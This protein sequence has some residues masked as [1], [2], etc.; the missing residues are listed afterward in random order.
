MLGHPARRLSR[1][2]NLSYMV[3][4]DRLLY[5]MFSNLV[6]VIR[7]IDP[8]RSKGNM[9][10][11]LWSVLQ[12]Q[13]WF[14]SCRARRLISPHQGK[15]LTTS[16]ADPVYFIHFTVWYGYFQPGA[17]LDWS[18]LSRTRSTKRLITTTTNLNMKIPEDRPRFSTGDSITVSTLLNERLGS[19]AIDVSDHCIDQ[20]RQTIQCYGDRTPNHTR[21]FDAIGQAFVVTDTVHTCRNFDALREWTSAK[22]NET[23]PYDPSATGWVCTLHTVIVTKQQSTWNLLRNLS[24]DTT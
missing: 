14:L 19:T 21:W 9:A 10:R 17:G 8:G 22:H 12:R 20:L 7:R 15:R 13:W 24:N 4:L 23:I 18:L 5:G 1:L 6:R 3:G 16:S 11:G 2:G